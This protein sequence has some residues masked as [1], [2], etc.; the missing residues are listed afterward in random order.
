M[1]KIGY[2]H[3]IWDWYFG[4]VAGEVRKCLRSDFFFT[5]RFLLF[6]IGDS[7]YIDPLD[8]GIKID[9]IILEMM[10]QLGVFLGQDNS[11]FSFDKTLKEVRL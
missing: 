11:I 5:I 10:A 3:E 1:I 7:L 6:R 9:K 4:S 2:C 8:F